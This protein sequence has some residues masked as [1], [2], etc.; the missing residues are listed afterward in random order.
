MPSA[1]SWSAA[2]TCSLQ[3]ADIPPWENIRYNQAHRIYLLIFLGV[4]HCF[5]FILFIFLR[6]LLLNFKYTWYRYLLV[7]ILSVLCE[8]SLPAL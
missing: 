4:A 2:R 6:K 7:R 8:W 3:E 5:D 1:V